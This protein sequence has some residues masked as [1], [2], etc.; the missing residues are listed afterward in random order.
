M[1][2]SESGL[3]PETGSIILPDWPAPANVH[4]F[5]T[6]RKGGFSSGSYSSMNLGDHVGDAREHV[7]A[8]RQAFAR[9]IG[10]DSGS[11]FWLRQVHGIDLADL[12]QQAMRLQKPLVADGATTTLSSVACVVMTADCMPVLLCDRSGSR[13]AAVHA[14][15]RGMEQGVIQQA[16]QYFEDPNEV[17]AYLGPTI[18]QRHFEVGVEVKS[19]FELRNPAYASAFA[20]SNSDT[21]GDSSFATNKYMCDLYSIARIL[22]EEHGVTKV[23][24]GDFCTYQQ[25]GLFYSYRRD[26]AQSGRM[27]S[28]IYLS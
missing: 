28:L 14:G 26:G 9:R 27:A 16:L 11:V 15:W 23:F 5:V 4:A 10:L 7:A 25:E 2:F 21:S 12:D 20:P 8:N 19:A 22:L 18:S 1:S 6:T 3:V 13:V 24:G 17:L